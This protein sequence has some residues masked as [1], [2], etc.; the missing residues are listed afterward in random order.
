MSTLGAYAQDT[1]NTGAKSTGTQK[2]CS[3]RS[4]TSSAGRLD[5]YR[6]NPSTAGQ[7]AAR[8]RKKAQANGYKIAGQDRYCKACGTVP[9][10]S[11]GVVGL[12]PSSSPHGSMSVHGLARCGYRWCGRCWGMIAQGRAADVGKVLEYVAKRDELET[13][14]EGD[15]EPRGLQVL[16]V[17]LTARH[18]FENSVQDLAD[19]IG[20]AWARTTSGRGGGRLREELV[21]YVKA[22][23]ITTD[24]LTVKSRRSGAH[25]HFHCLFVVRPQGRSKRQVEREFGDVLWSQWERGANRAGLEVARSGYQCESVKSVEQA[26]AYV[27]KMEKLMHQEDAWD[28]TSELTAGHVKTASSGRVSPEE[29]LR[30]IALAQEQGESVLVEK[31]SRQFQAIEVALKGKRW[32]TWS[33]NIR[34]WAQLGEEQTDEELAN[35]VDDLEGCVHV[36]DHEEVK[37]HLEVFHEVLGAIEVA[38]REEVLELLLDSFGIAYSKVLAVDFSESVVSEVRRKCGNA[39]ELGEDRK[40]L[41]GGKAAQN[42]SE[43][44]LTLAL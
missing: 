18:T 40:N 31:L 24:D 32:L 21:G 8:Q 15:T 6:N 20:D 30:N 3:G 19:R 23:E 33:R 4:A 7:G 10:M 34:A 1:A 35:A 16:M 12:K 27:V 29:L 38:L 39:P 17:T 36:V 25:L 14:P 9:V 42:Q 44:Q 11:S 2:R 28:A 26:S 41:L 13:L 5:K 22:L 43:E 37:S